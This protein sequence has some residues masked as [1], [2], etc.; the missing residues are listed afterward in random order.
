MADVDLDRLFSRYDPVVVTDVWDTGSVGGTEKEERSGPILPYL[1][2]IMGVSDR[3]G[4]V[5]FTA[6]IDGKRYKVKD[7]VHGFTINEIAEEGVY[8]TK[9]GTNWFIPAPEG[10][11]TSIRKDLGP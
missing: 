8:L 6:V 1:T 11:F 4:N 10:R 7:E 9:W 5:R 2:G 3:Q